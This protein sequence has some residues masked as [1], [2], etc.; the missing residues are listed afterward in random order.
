[1]RD[2]S[3]SPAPGTRRTG[4]PWLW[5]VTSLELTADT[6]QHVHA[7]FALQQLIR[8]GLG[9]GLNQARVYAQ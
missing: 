7:G 8:A 9:L 1:M 2:A 3:A 4:Q 6:W 5:N